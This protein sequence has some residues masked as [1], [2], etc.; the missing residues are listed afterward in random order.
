MAEGSALSVITSSS[1][2]MPIAYGTLP[3]AMFR[4][5]PV[6]SLTGSMSASALLAPVENWFRLPVVREFLQSLLSTRHNTEL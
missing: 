2:Q 5:A 4:I 6:P 3:P 1:C